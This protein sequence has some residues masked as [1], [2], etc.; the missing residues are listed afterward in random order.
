M[1][2]FSRNENPPPETTYLNA[3]RKFE[4]GRP[5]G[6]RDNSPAFQRWD[7]CHARKSPEGTA[8]RWCPWGTVQPSRRDSNSID[9]N[10]GVETP[11]YSRMSL[12]DKLGSNLRKGITTNEKHQTPG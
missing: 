7:L 3:F 12:R 8:E 10:P 6:T 4:N 5:E 2:E 11:G 9:H 1:T